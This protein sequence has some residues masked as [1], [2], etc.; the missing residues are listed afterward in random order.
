MDP[1]TSGG[2]G[3][4]SERND[5][6]GRDVLYRSLFEHALMEVHIWR[7]VRDERGEIV[8][9]RLVDANGAALRSWRR[10]LEDILGKTTEEIF[11]GAD[12]VRTFL[13]LVEEIIA[14]GQPKEW[15]TPFDGTS[16]VLHMVS[17]PI[18]EYFVS[19][20]FDVTADRVRERKLGDALRSL[21][22]AT[23]AGGVGLWDWDFGTN[24]VRYSDEWKRQIGYQ[25]DELPDRFESWQSRLHPDDLESAL[26]EMHATIVDPTRPHDVTFRLRHKDGSYRWIL[27]QSAVITDDEGRP[28]R[29]LGSHID[30]TERR[31]LEARISQA[32]KVEAIGT[33]AAGIAHDF[34]NL[35]GAIAGN[36]TLL[37]DLLP[38]DQEA[39]TLHR[40]LEDATRRAAALTSQLLTFAKGGSPVRDVTSIRELVIESARFV[41]R[42]SNCRCVFA[43][44]EELDAVDADLGQLNQ[45]L[46]NLVINAMQAMPEGGSIE[47]AADNV[48]LGA[49]AE[50]GLPPG[51]YVRIAVQDEGPGIAPGDL[52]KIFDPFFTTKP[53][54]S[55]LGLATSQSIVTR[56]G[57]RITV[58][59]RPGSGARFEILLPSSGAVPRV[60]P[61][62]LVVGGGGRILV[63]DDDE[64]LRRVF[65]RLLARIGYDSDVCA[66]GDSACR[67]Y[68]AA[69]REGRRYDAVILDLTAPGGR[70]G[71]HVLPEL[72]HLDP[73]VVA[74][75]TSGYA[76]DD[77]LAHYERHGFNGRLP[78]PIDV[79]QMSV[80]LA[81]VLR[82]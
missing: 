75:V 23:Q 78:K 49:D 7:V 31:R 57:G 41:T 8:T 22:Q 65:Q 19:T 72:R 6:I 17:I 81:R 9:W 15:E 39:A 37:R 68:E 64:A 55:G 21:N 71:A 48:V 50:P 11:P 61:A 1:V 66:D 38:R 5:D 51:R 26:A 77:I 76:H 10:R 56:H 25:P 43:V 20:G 2:Q 44:A 32:E 70:G 47:V 27:A 54:G 62:A 52:P 45:V 46:N 73:Q 60:A 53:T 79:V 42:G 74:L 63:M 29:M 16:Q 69:L 40:D 12:P 14:T 18:G 30:I 80:E 3:G 4:P 67:L 28:I 13:P 35:L 33:L 59:S 36:L 34:N 24:T 82:H 58:A